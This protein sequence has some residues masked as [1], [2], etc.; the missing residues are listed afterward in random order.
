MKKTGFKYFLCIL[1]IIS[2]VASG[3]VT[4]LLPV[5]SGMYSK[6]FNTQITM[7]I[8]IFIW[9]TIVPLYAILISFYRISILLLTMKGFE[10]STIKQIQI[11]KIA[12]AIEFI[13]YIYACIRYKNILPFIILCGTII[14]YLLSALIKEILVDGQ[15]YYEDSNLAI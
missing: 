4:L 15:K 3:I 7:D 10:N 5:L 12:S 1:S 9:I 14:I 6:I 11:V 2:M 8:I 13:L